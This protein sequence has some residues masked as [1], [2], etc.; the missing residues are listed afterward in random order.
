MQIVKNEIRQWIKLKKQYDKQSI[1]D[2]KKNKWKNSDIYLKLFKS[3]NI[4]NCK[5]II[6]EGFKDISIKSKASYYFCTPW[7]IEGV[8]NNNTKYIKWKEDWGQPTVKKLK[9][10]L[11]DNNYKEIELKATAFLYGYSQTIAK[12]TNY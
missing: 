12:M 10:I 11:I 5:K 2:C 9:K 7:K 1:K 4:Q 8:K 6:E 3:N